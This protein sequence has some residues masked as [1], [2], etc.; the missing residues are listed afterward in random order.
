MCAGKG[1]DRDRPHGPLVLAER[2]IS[3]R[4]GFQPTT[5]GAGAFGRLPLLAEAR[6][7]G[8]RDRFADCIPIVKIRLTLRQQ[9]EVFVPFGR[10][11]G[12]AAFRLRIRLRPCTLMPSL[13]VKLGN[14]R[15]EK[16]P[17]LRRRA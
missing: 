15:V 4:G 14:L 11:I 16:L 17:T 7:A 3:L 9:E 1:A 6:A 10:P 5:L 8:G 2:V 12:D 13:E